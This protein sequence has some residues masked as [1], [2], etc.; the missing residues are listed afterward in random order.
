LKK[1]EK[2]KTIKEKKAKEKKKRKGFLK[3]HVKKYK[4]TP[5]SLKEI[6]QIWH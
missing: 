5:R 3:V 1:K 4:C 6:F 2:R